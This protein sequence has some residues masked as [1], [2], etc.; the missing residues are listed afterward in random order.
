MVKYWDK[1]TEM[2]GQQN[3]N[4]YNIYHEKKLVV[5]VYCFTALSKSLS[6]TPD[7]W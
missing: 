7:A 6:G 2:H 5:L 1:Y 3:V 4:I